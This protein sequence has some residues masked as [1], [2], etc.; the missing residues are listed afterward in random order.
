M[1]DSGTRSAGSRLEGKVAVVTGG[2]GGLGLGMAMGLA[3]FQIEMVESL[4]ATI[5]ALEL[6][7][8]PRRDSL[9]PG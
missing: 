5:A 2:N 6:R 8:A 3:G 4:D 9:R 7:H 1:P